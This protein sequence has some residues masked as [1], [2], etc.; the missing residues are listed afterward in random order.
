MWD[1][2]WRFLWKLYFWPMSVAFVLSVPMAVWHNWLLGSVDTAFTTICLVAVFGYTYRRRIG[3]RA[4]WRTFVPILLAWDVVL[5]VLED[6]AG[7]LTS[8]PPVI[9][10]LLVSLLLATSAPAFLGLVLYGFASPTLWQARPDD[11]LLS[12]PASDL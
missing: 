8:G 10:F 7:K 1:S 2:A 6:F 12:T 3:S 4:F 5:F 9:R 11:D